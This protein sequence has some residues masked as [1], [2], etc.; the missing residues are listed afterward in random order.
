MER[1]KGV[2]REAGLASVDAEARRLVEAA[3]GRSTAELLLQPEVDD[4][5]EAAAVSLA[6][7]RAAGEPLQ[8]V[9]GVA[10]FRRLDLAVG[11]GVFVPRPETELVVEKGLERLPQGGTV[12]DVGTGS[13]AI[14]LSIADERPDARV[15]ATER[16]SDAVEWVRRNRDSTGKHIEIIEG[17][18]FDGLPEDL[19]GQ[20]DVVISNPPYVANAERSTLPPD[21]V[22]QEPHGALFGGDA[23][24][25]IIERL[26]SE[27]LDWLRPQGWLVLEIGAG[28]GPK[29]HS[30][31]DG[32]GY[33]EVKIG[34]DYANWPR[35][36]EARR[37]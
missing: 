19:R 10:G 25:D 18:V 1:V 33:E 9:T 16:F 29:V 4:S 6:R 8:Y 34:V 36:A 3:T 28:Q 35:V 15:F 14:A 32:L 31:L 22:E 2:L 30:L 37:P 23:G 21:V 26:A 12:V 24:M 5:V 7:R 20:F 27:S 11:P 17:D 13:G